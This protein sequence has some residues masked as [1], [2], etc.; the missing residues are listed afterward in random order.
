MTHPPPRQAPRRPAAQ[1]GRLAGLAAAA[2][3][4]LQLAGLP[5]TASA[6]PLD[7]IRRQVEAS[8]FDAAWATAQANPQLIGDVHFDFPYGVAAINTGHVAE[9]LLALERHLA[10][11]PANDRAR[12]ELARGYFLLGEFTRARAE[13]E[14]VLRYNPPAGVR[15]S[16]AGFLQAMQVREDAGG[17]AVARLYAEA[18]FGHD[19]NVNGGTFHDNID[20]AGNAFPLDASSR[21]VGDGYGELAVGG[22]QVMRVSNRLSVFAGADLD[23]RSNFVQHPYDLGTAGGYIGLTQLG[24][25]ALWRLTLGGNE[26]QVGGNRY[27][28]T[29]QAQGEAN[30]SFGPALALQAFAQYGEMRYNAANEVLDART[31]TAGAVLTYTDA[32]LAGAPSSGVR[33][34]YTQEQNLRLRDD[35]GHQLSLLRLFGAFSP[36]ERLRITFGV[37]FYQRVFG[38]PDIVL[39]TVRHD[40]S[41]GAD[42]VANYAL[43][44]R[45]SL[46]GDLLWSNTHSNQQLFETRRSSAQLKLRYQY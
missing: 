6:A 18:G 10:A 28:D 13:F 27:R 26:L 3:L 40:H 44:A 29:A 8:Q 24:A 20:L 30:F 16:I 34:S 12:L 7:D 33:L 31:S 21:Q 25:G 22:Q 41:V 35:L 45:W 23:Q 42:I 9:G 46:R 11:V 38:G 15:A 32:E 39:G 2:A 19:S 37:T 5:G 43:D 36:L 4:A 17:R 1:R 14:F